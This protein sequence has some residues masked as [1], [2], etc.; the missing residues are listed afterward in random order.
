MSNNFSQ[1]DEFGGGA[2]GASAAGGGKKTWLTRKEWIAKKREEERKEEVARS[3]RNQN[4]LTG[5]LKK[6]KDNSGAAPSNDDQ[7]GAA[8]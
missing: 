6:P 2:G 8:T 5:F 1:R 3:M 7:S 4:V